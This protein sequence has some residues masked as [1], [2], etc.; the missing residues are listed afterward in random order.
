MV[1]QITL[2]IQTLEPHKRQQESIIPQ[3]INMDMVF[4]VMQM[5]QI[6]LVV[7]AAEAA[8]ATGEELEVMVKVG[9][10]APHTYRDMLGV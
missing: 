7:G 5:K 10:V 4:S 6:P 3:I 8:Q 9:L 1:I 2:P